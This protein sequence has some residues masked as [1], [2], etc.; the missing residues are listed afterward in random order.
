VA[1]SQFNRSRMVFMEYLFSLENR[2]EF[3]IIFEIRYGGFHNS[4][5]ESKDS[6]GA[7]IYPERSGKRFSVLKYC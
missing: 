4:Y 3:S 2:I 5:G 1:A 6:R 7:P